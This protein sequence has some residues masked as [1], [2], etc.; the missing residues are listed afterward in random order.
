MAIFFCLPLSFQ[1]DDQLTV[2]IEVIALFIVLLRIVVR[3]AGVTTA[4]KQNGGDEYGIEQNK[5]GDE[6][7]ERCH[8]THLLRLWICLDA[9]WAGIGAGVAPASEE[10]F[11][12]D[13]Q[14]EFA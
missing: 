8:I 10:G 12:W 11:G 4:Q 13:G 3:N 2:V 1:A 5:P 14:M 9:L 7:D 6:D